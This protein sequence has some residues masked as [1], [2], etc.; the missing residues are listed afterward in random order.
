[1]QK[2]FEVLF[3]SSQDENKKTLL[4]VC[5]DLPVKA[6]TVYTFAQAK[7]FLSAHQVR[8]VFCDELLPDGSYREVLAV[9]RTASPIAQ[10]V[11]VMRDGEWQEYLEALRL[12]VQEVL[13]PP[14]LPI[15]IDLA[16]IHSFQRIEREL[17]SPV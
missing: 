11:L 1:M 6:R 12:G 8:M 7:Q 10:F 15:D 16:F 13:R 14:L 2:P 4:G 17:V 5:R 3:V 9:L